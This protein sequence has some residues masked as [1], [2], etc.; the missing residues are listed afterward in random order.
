[1]ARL[2]NDEYGRGIEIHSV[3]LKYLP[4]VDAHGGRGRLEGRKN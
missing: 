1:M 3:K 4:D 2:L